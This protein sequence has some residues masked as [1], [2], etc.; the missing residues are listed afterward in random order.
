VLT[1]SR[2]RSRAPQHTVPVSWIASSISCSASIIPRTEDV[3]AGGQELRD[4]Q[5]VAADLACP[6][7]VL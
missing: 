4:G 2:R 5:A 7:L 3:Y 6:V 1:E